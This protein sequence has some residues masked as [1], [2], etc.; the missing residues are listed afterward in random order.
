MDKKKIVSYLPFVALGLA[1]LAIIMLFLPN[2]VMKEDTD[3]TYSALQL[4]FGAE[5][6]VMTQKIG[7]LAFS[8]IGLLKVLL[9]IAAAALI[10]WNTFG[11]KP[12]KIY[13]YVAAGCLA[14]AALLFFCSVGFASIAKDYA[15]TMKALDMEKSDVF[16]LGAGAVIGGIVSLLGAAATI[17]PVVLEK[18]EK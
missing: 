10:A 8:I 12:D 11:N 15:D 4:A 2:I 3:Y 18:L 1:V 5:E 7:V 13:T 17:A 16:K 14:L 6:K 9:P